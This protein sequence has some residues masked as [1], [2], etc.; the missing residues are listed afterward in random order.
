MDLLVILPV[1]LVTTHRCF[2]T[3]IKVDKLK[4]VLKA[5][6]FCYLHILQNI[7]YKTRQFFSKCYLI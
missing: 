6:F 2:K 7:K 4:I 1:Q 5:S 3:D